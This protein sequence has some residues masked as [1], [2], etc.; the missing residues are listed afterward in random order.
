MLTAF[1]NYRLGCNYAVNNY[2]NNQQWLTGFCYLFMTYQ[3]SQ[4]PFSNFSRLIVTLTL[5]ITSLQHISTQ[6]QK[7]VLKTSDYCPR[8]TT[9]I[10]NWL[11]SSAS[12]DLK[13]ISGPCGIGFTPSADSNDL[14]FVSCQ[15]LRCFSIR[16]RHRRQ[17]WLGLHSTNTSISIPVRWYGSS[18]IKH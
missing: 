5:L 7:V 4:T 13:A 14:F 9:L 1:V 16:R 8:Y 12:I 2:S 11:K 17:C 6:H 18:T 15:L 3:R 10:R